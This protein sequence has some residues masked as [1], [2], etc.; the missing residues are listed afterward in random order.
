MILGCVN[1]ILPT[2]SLLVG[3][4]RPKMLVTQFYYL[5]KLFLILIVL[6]FSHLHYDHIW[7]IKRKSHLKI[8]HPAQYRICTLPSF[9]PVGLI[10]PRMLVTHFYFL[11]KLF[12]FLIVL[13]FSH[14]HYD[15][16]WSMKI[17]SHLKITYPAA[18]KIFTLPSFP[19][20]SFSKQTH[21]ITLPPIYNPNIL[22]PEAKEVAF[23]SRVQE[24]KVVIVELYFVYSHSHF[25]QF[26]LFG[27]VVLVI[28]AW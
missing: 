9:P 20:T 27:F 5:R 14:L 22:P 7:S 28:S 15:H 13:T 25:L 26:S 4:M 17:K 1:L 3:L 10:R 2:P 21:W 16:I 8:T 24:V 23:F 6:T 18:Y 19:L 12:L 11:R